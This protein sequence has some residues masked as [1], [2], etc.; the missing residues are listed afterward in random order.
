MATPT[1]PQAGGEKSIEY[2]Q[3]KAAPLA[4]ESQE[5]F[6]AAILAFHKGKAVVNISNG[7]CK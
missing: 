3:S 5:T 7:M 6:T 2:Y 4:G 1:K